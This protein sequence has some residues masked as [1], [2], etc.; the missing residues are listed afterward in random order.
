MADF[1]FW[2]IEDEG[3]WLSPEAKEME[4]RDREKRLDNHDE[5]AW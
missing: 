5:D 2:A 1:W 4:R 3:D